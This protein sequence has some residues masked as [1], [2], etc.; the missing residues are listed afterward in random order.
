MG[1]A[2][3]QKGCNMRLQEL[4]PEQRMFML[5]KGDPKTG[6]DIAA[7]S[8]ASYGPTYTFDM[9]NRMESVKHYYTKIVPRPDI[10]ANIEYDRF[11]DFS[12]MYN[13]LLTLEKNCPYRNIIYS[14][15]TSLARKSMNTMLNTRQ[16]SAAVKSGQK[17]DTKNRGGIIMHE[18]EDFGGEAN[19]IMMSLDALLAISIIHNVNVI[20]TAH[21]IS[22]EA[23]AFRP[24]RVLLTGGKKVAA[25]IP[26]SFNEAYH[27]FVATEGGMEIGVDDVTR[28]YIA[29]TRT[30]G[31]DWAATA[32]DIPSKIEFTAGLTSGLFFEELFKNVRLANESEVS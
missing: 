29:F 11:H 28:H 2:N 4:M 5:F 18:I 16:P 1:I 3:H 7:H 8:L 31:V 6:K 9:D 12:S 15:L 26:V 22:P 13:R 19:A 10:I 17:S 25:E 20:M 23:G 30:V 32:L 24:M 14:S 27:F 21:I